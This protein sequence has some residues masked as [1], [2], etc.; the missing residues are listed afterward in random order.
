MTE[1][2]LVQLLSASK[3]TAVVAH[4]LG[5]S[6]WSDGGVEHSLMRLTTD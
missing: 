2:G 5:I 1:Q 3:V 4:A 6:G